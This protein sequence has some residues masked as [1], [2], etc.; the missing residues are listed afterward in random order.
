M[1][2]SAPSLLEIRKQGNMRSSSQQLES[3]AKRY[4]RRQIPFFSSIPI[5]ITNAS[6]HN[7]Q[8]NTHNS[9]TTT[10]PQSSLATAATTPMALTSSYLEREGGALGQ[11][12]EA[13]ILDH[14]V[15]V[16][17]HTSM[18]TIPG[19]LL[20][21]TGTPTV[22]RICLAPVGPEVTQVKDMVS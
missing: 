19:R 18:M 22:Q 20:Q 8:S 1:S 2:I 5:H 15:A 10:T 11:M 4:K 21:D 12:S 17:A 3:N 16:A 6:S 9:H 14:L 13:Q 7:N